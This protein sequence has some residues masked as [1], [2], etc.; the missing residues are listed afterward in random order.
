MT[1]ARVREFNSKPPEVIAEPKILDNSTPK[2]SAKPEKKTTDDLP[3][4]YYRSLL[5]LK[6]AGKELKQIHQIDTFVCA[7][8]VSA[9]GS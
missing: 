6:K 7:V 4:M 3:K 2:S 1:C 8:N 5:T 9:T